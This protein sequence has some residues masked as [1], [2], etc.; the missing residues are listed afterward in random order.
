MA[1]I[2][3]FAGGGKPPGIIVTFQPGLSDKK[4]VNLMIVAKL[5]PMQAANG[6]RKLLEVHEGVRALS[7]K[8]QARV[9]QYILTMKNTLAKQDDVTIREYPFTSP[10]TQATSL[11][12]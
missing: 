5:D 4:P 3:N 6:E 2:E 12:Q 7:E 10:T 9:A 11:M 1:S 8:S